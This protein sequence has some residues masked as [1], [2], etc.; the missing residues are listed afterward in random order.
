MRLPLLLLAGA[1]SAD[2]APAPAPVPPPRAKKDDSLE[3]D[4]KLLQGRWRPL[5]TAGKLPDRFQI[6][7]HKS[8]LVISYARDGGGFMVQVVTIT[9]PFELKQVGNKRR[10]SPSKKGTGVSEITYRVEGDRLIIEGGTCGAKIA[11]QGEWK[12]APEGEAP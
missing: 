12:R 5:N 10:L 9:A 6:E 3:K 1:L 2:A 4:L 11:L 7:F 8:E